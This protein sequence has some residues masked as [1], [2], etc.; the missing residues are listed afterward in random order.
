MKIRAGVWRESS[1]ALLE[2]Q[3][4]GP[5]ADLK[6][7]EEEDNT[8]GKSGEGVE[9]GA[10]GRK[11]NNRTRGAWGGYVRCE[12]LRRGISRGRGGQLTK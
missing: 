11:I 2:S 6:R 10:N 5:R 7:K 4:G 8:Y 9:G 12:D 1:E 3:R